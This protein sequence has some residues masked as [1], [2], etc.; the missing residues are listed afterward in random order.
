[1]MKKVASAPMKKEEAPKGPKNRPPLFKGSICKFCG[2]C[3]GGDRVRK[4]LSPLS[5]L[6]T[7]AAPH[8]LDG[9]CWDGEKC[10]WAHGD[11]D[12]IQNRQLEPQ[13]GAPKPGDPFANAGP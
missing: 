3:V 6:R 12:L 4:Q 11:H 9:Y 2:G 8:W 13:P 5:T 10:G 1:M 7:V